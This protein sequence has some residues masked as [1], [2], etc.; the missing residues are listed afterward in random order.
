MKKNKNEGE[1]SQW[2]LLGWCEGQRDTQGGFF[3]KMIL[4]E[5]VSFR[6][7]IIHENQ[8]CFILDSELFKIKLPHFFLNNGQIS[9]N[10][11]IILDIVLL[12][13]LSLVGG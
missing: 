6:I 1:I 11:K 5:V 13:P 7:L 3:V 9:G 4:N 12:F 10:F 8:G 2:R